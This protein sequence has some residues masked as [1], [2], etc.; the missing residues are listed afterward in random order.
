MN[1]FRSELDNESNHLGVVKFG[2]YPDSR[3]SFLTEEHESVHRSCHVAR[4]ASL[5]HSGLCW[6]AERKGLDASILRPLLVSPSIFS[7]INV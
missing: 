4:D 1:E 6:V 7:S 3:A 2:L 5:L